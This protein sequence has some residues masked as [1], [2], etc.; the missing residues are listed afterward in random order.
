MPADHARPLIV[1]E[2]APRPASRP[3]VVVDCSVIAAAVFAEPQC[4][5]AWE[6]LAGRSLHAPWLIDIEMG[7][8]ALKKSQPRHKDIAEAGLG[9]FQ[10]LDITRYAVDVAALIQLATRYRLTAYDAAYLLVASELRA[11]L[12]TF[13]EKLGSAAR[14]HMASLP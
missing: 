14:R 11:P 12:L 5:Q 8:V 7:S 2:P 1:A 3:P 6:V 9:H 4:E 10:D 13:D